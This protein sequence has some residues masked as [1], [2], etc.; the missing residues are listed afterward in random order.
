MDRRMASVSL[1]ARTVRPA[2]RVEVG[3]AYPSITDFRAANGTETLP[4]TAPFNIW[5]QLGLHQLMSIA[6]GRRNVTDFSA[7]GAISFGEELHI[8]TKEPQASAPI[9]KLQLRNDTFDYAFYQ[10]DLEDFKFEG[11]NY[12]TNCTQYSQQKGYIPSSGS[13][14]TSFAA[15]ETSH[16]AGDVPQAIW[17]AGTSSALS[18]RKLSR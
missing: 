10:T 17:D 3:L 2:D 9:N 15:C 7:G 12:S 6:L 14:D 16:D 8:P 1:F 5:S 18:A 11:S 13:N 4:P